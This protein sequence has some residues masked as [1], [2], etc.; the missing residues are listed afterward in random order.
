M[1]LEDPENY[2][3]YFMQAHFNQIY[4]TSLSEYKSL[5]SQARPHLV[6]THYTELAESKDII[7]MR[8]ELGLDPKTSTCPISL[9]QAQVLVHQFQKFYV[10]HSPSKW[11]LVTTFNSN[12]SDFNHYK[13]IKEAETFE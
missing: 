11:E 8:G 5:G 6:L 12:P 10:T 7:L 1:P 4:F 13:L 2:E 3:F 9:S